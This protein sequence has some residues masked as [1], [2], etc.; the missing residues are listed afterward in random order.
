MGNEKS[1]QNVIININKSIPGHHN[2]VCYSNEPKNK[3]N[4]SKMISFCPW[5]TSIWESASSAVFATAAVVIPTT[6]LVLVSKHCGS[7]MA[8]DTIVPMSAGIPFRAWR[9]FDYPRHRSDLL[10]RKLV[11]MRI[12]TCGKQT[13]REIKF[14][15]RLFGEIANE[16]QHS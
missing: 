8:I 2:Y 16:T 15:A 14:V 12:L 1:Y 5:M 11:I 13:L 7:D 4:L 3:Q 9:G 6:H 10:L